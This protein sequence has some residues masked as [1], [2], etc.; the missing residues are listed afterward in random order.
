[1]TSPQTAQENELAMKLGRYKKDDRLNC[2]ATTPRQ[3]ERPDPKG[4]QPESACPTVAATHTLHQKVCN[5]KS[6]GWSWQILRAAST[7]M[8][9]SKLTMKCNLLAISETLQMI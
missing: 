6:E 2:Q 3:S 8:L 9:I 4:K 1:M 5:Q 7:Q